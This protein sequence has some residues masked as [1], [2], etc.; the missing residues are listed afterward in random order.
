MSNNQVSAAPPE[1]ARRAPVWLGVAMTVVGLLSM[2]AGVVIWVTGVGFDPRHAPGMKLDN[3][4]RM[5][6]TDPADVPAEWWTRIDNDHNREFRI[7]SPVESPI[8]CVAQGPSTEGHLYDAFRYE[9][10]QDAAGLR[11]RYSVDPP[12]DFFLYCY[13]VPS[14]GSP[15]DPSTT[16]D[17]LPVYVTWGVNA[18]ALGARF[19]PLGSG[20]MLVAVGLL[21]WISRVRRGPS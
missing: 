3:V 11:L 14:S 20:A 2:A 5:I 8:A 4:Y 7:W 13:A 12:R 10:Q 17:D 1:K 18:A 9:G 21:L 19:I 16:V 6:T 15:S